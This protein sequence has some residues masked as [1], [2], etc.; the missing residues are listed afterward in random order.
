M[1][2]TTKGIYYPGDYTSVADIPKDLKEMAESIEKVIDNEAYDDTQIQEYIS[3]LKVKDTELE[4]E[5]ERLREDLNNTVPSISGSG[6]NVT[7][8]GTAKAR[9]KSFEISG[10]SWQ[11]TR[12]GKNLT[13]YEDW[14]RI[15]AV[16]SLNISKDTLTYSVVNNSYGLWD[17][18]RI[19]KANTEY[20]V[21]CDYTFS[22]T[23]G[24][25]YGIRVK[26]GETWDLPANSNILNFT[27]DDTGRII[28]AFYIGTPYTGENATLAIK[29]I[30]LYEG[31]YTADNIPDYEQYGAMP[32]PEFKSPI[33]NVSGSADFY[34]VPELADISKFTAEGY[35]N[36]LGTISSPSG[37]GEKATELVK[38][39]PNTNYTFFIINTNSNFDNW[40]GVG[41]YEQ[42]STSSFIKRNTST[43]SFKYN[44]TTSEKTNYVILSARNLKEA[45]NVSFYE[46]SKNQSFTFPLS[47][48]QRLMLGDYLA[49]DGIHHKRGQVELDGTEEIELWSTTQSGYKRFAIKKTGIKYSENGLCSHFVYYKNQTEQTQEGTSI[50]IV[51][52]Y[53]TIKVDEAIASTVNELKTYL[54]SQKSVDTPVILEYDLSQED[55]ETYTTEQQTVHNEIKKTAKSYG[56]TTHIFSTDEISL[57]FDVEA[58]A[59][60]Q[61]MFNN[62]Q[63]QILA[64]E[65]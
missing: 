41:E 36:G 15:S 23:F 50:C 54:A 57:I 28:L 44:F 13:N 22:G 51:D 21:F 4:A 55:I 34:I 52:N 1:S 62:L 35:V 26:R 3:E 47:E 30:R 7:L 25:Q 12:S 31:T 48:G 9:F 65:V 33:R 39:K 61:T 14:T 18:E 37:K 63:A 32:S 2:K 17:I 42:K 20:T 49:D 38:V 59:D 40:I 46:T 27:T 16:G 45:T 8:N 58:L 5:N 11:E 60:I 6:E 56:D 10:N 64:G 24:S 19:L 29:N 53:I 43:S